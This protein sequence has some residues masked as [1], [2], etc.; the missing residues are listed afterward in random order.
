[1][2]RRRALITFLVALEVL[3]C[4]AVI[5]LAVALRGA[6]PQTRLFYEADTQATETVEER[7]TVEGTAI[8]DLSNRYGDVVVNT[9]GG[10][11]IVVRAT[12]EVWGEDEADAQNK[13]AALK[14][15][16][17]LDGNRLLVRVEN[18]DENTLTMM[19]NFKASTVRFE[20]T[21]PEN[22]D[23][24]I[25]NT[26]GDID[27]EGVQGYANLSDSFGDITVRQVR[28]EIRVSVRN[29]NLS[30]L[31][32]GGEEEAMTLSNR[33]GEIAVR[34]AVA[35][36]IT[37]DQENGGVALRNVSVVDE[38][39]LENTYGGIGLTGIEAGRITV[40]SRN[41][42]VILHDAALTGF[43]EIV[44]H[45]GDVTLTDVWARSYEIA[46]ENGD[47]D[48]DGGQGML[49]LSNGYG[50]TRVVRARQAILDIESHNGRIVFE[51]SL[52]DTASFHRVEQKYG[53]VLLQ[54]PADTAI[55]IDAAT[56]LGKVRSQFDVLVKGGA[57]EKEDGGDKGRLYGD[58]NGGGPRL[59]I[60]N[61]NGNI[62]LEAIDVP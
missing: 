31:D 48:L 1:M 46:T 49:K 6:Y 10:D 54:L 12:K 28:G 51:G 44:N 52:D 45:Y 24:V 25:V 56:K 20:V 19:G 37:I 3:I 40:Q 58:I 23:L 27:V 42:D 35:R 50:D 9:D 47:I 7:F 13:L 62:T 17:N 43:L 16:M 15:P 26:N 53:S 59:R 39:T 8:L 55:T 22:S 11:Q 2:K 38:I 4:V 29:G 21:V 41:G 5:G 34:K 61:S 36:A 60:E 33:F 30:V 18:P 14:I 57:P 32:S